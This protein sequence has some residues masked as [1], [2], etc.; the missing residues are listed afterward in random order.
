MVSKLVLALALVT[1]V[2]CKSKKRPES[3]NR[4][5][6]KQVQKQEVSLPGAQV[7]NELINNGDKP[8]IDLQSGGL[9]KD[10][11]PPKVDNSTSVQ[12]TDEAKPAPSSAVAAAPVVVD[13]DSKTVSGVQVIVPESTYTK[14]MEAPSS[15]IKDL[16]EVKVPSQAGANPMNDEK[17]AAEVRNKLD[18]KA[19]AAETNEK[20]A[21]HEQ[22]ANFT[23]YA[24]VHG[25]QDQG[26]AGMSFTIT[27]HMPNNPDETHIRNQLSV[28]GG[29]TPDGGIGYSR[30][31]AVWENWKLVKKE[32]KKGASSG[33]KTESE[34]SE[35][36]DVDMWQYLISRDGNI[37][38][39][40]RYRM[41]KDKKTDHVLVHEAKTATEAEYKKKWQE[42]KQFWYQKTR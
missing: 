2:G 22:W 19:A 24:V 11:I 1:M 25:Q 40:T 6:Q 42:M 33:K 17:V 27:D 3:V 34:I 5:V 38:Q 16:Q 9:S 8:T 13:T 18:A 30:V 41:V 35:Q 7:G 26:P 23:E 20:S 31:Q 4:N 15:V 14:Q 28:F 39:F 36:F 29:P 12:G 32:N 21:D 10:P 37:A